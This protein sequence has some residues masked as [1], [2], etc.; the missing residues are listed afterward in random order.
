MTATV[1]I[2]LDEALQ[3]R[4]ARLSKSTGRTRSDLV[5]EALE[6]QLALVEF[7]TARSRTRPFA[8]RAGFLTDDDVF[9]VVS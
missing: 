2:R 3:K 6:R 4:L 1:T 7:E 8:E 5:R 9:R